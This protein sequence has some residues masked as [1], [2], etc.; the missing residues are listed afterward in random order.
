M[1]MGQVQLGTYPPLT[2]LYPV[3]LGLI[4]D[5]GWDWDEFSTQTWGWVGRSGSSH[6][7]HI[8]IYI[9]IVVNLIS[10]LNRITMKE[11]RK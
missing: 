6:P 8:Y 2:H 11:T 9:Y 5:L 4:W 1:E 7:T 3:Y 10:F